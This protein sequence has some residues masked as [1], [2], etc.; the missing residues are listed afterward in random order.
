MKMAQSRWEEFSAA[1]IC[2]KTEE[3]RER[4]VWIGENFEEVKRTSTIFRFT[5]FW[6]T[7]KAH[8]QDERISECIQCAYILYLYAS[9]TVVASTQVS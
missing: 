5:I 2:G 1:R 4:L 9:K 3:N 8:A 7:L 6:C